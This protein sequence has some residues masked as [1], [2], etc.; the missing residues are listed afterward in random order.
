M[1]RCIPLNKN[2]GVRPIGVGEI[3]RRIVGKAIGWVFKSDIQKAAGPLQVSM[4]VQGGAEAAIHAMK[5]VFERDENEAVILIDAKNAFNSLNRNVAL[6]NIQYICPPISKILI[7]TYRRR[8]RGE[9]LRS[10]EGTTQG[11]NL[12]MSFYGLATSLLLHKLKLVCE[13]I[14]QVWPAD[15]VTG[16]GKIRDLREWWDNVIVEGEKIGYYVNENKSWLIL[17]DPSKLDQ[18]KRNIFKHTNKNYC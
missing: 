12:A 3:I 15:D 5:E 8:G 13:R 14:K 11:D 18:V 1:Q 7:N 6:R 17:K 10:Q 2:P 9:E 16:A 4:G